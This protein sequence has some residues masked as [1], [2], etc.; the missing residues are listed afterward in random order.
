MAG[1]GAV[2]VTAM[3]EP[4]RVLDALRDDPAVV[5]ATEGRI[6]P[7]YHPEVCCMCRWVAWN[8]DCGHPESD[9]IES[10]HDHCDMHGGT[11]R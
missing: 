3:T 8:E 9:G 7:E 2:D 6:Y 10:P 5:A 11:P 1:S 4:K